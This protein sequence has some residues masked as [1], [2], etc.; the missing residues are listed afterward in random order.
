[1]SD[2]EKSIPKDWADQVEEEPKEI[3]RKESDIEEEKVFRTEVREAWVFLL[4]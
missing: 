4:I 3:S 2:K 1:M